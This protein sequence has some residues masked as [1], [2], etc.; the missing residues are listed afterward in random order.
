MHR[1]PS[2][3]SSY[4]VVKTDRQE[5]ACQEHILAL[6]CEEGLL[7]IFGKQKAQPGVLPRLQHA[8]EQVASQAS[9][10]ERHCAC[11]EEA[12]GGLE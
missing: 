3:R 5:G 10:P 7:V 6:A 2:L 8:P 11:Q 9:A 4:V 12:L 1:E